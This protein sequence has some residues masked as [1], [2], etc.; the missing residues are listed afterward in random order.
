MNCIT[1]SLIACLLD[2]NYNINNIE[3]WNWLNWRLCIPSDIKDTL[4]TLV[5]FQSVLWEIWRY[6][7]GC[8]S[9]E[10]LNSKQSNVTEVYAI[11][12][13]PKEMFL[14]QL[15]CSHCIWQQIKGWWAILSWKTS[16]LDQF[17]QNWQN[18]R[19]KWLL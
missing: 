18:E 7:F 5:F 4:F 2:F 1:F 16:Q 13:C 6:K 15:L 9:W 12:N 11:Y 19:K 17:P 3:R 10:I 14:C 8:E